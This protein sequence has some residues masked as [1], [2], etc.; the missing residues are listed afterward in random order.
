MFLDSLLWKK[1]ST[2]YTCCGSVVAGTYIYFLIPK[3]QPQNVGEAL[4]RVGFDSIE[5]ASA[6]DLKK[7][8]AAYKLA[9]AKADFKGIEGV[10]ITEE[11]PDE[12]AVEQLKGGCRRLSYGATTTQNKEN[13]VHYCVVPITIAKTL[14][15]RGIKFLD[16]TSSKHDA[17]WVQ[18]ADALIKSG[19]AGEGMTSDT[20]KDQKIQIMKSSCSDLSTAPTTSGRFSTFL[21]V[22]TNY[23]SD[24][25]LS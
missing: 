17:I 11:T 22:A 8:L 14:E 25:G 20:P 16:T 7:I 23:C 24:K 21:D 10:N 15:N 5:N 18:R 13:A 9:S 19:K 2:A 4:D 1:F 6:A 12:E 3:S